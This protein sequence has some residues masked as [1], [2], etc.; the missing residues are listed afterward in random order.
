MT[1]VLSA[2]LLLLLPFAAGAAEPKPKP[3]PAVEAPST[4]EAG[5]ADALAA[6]QRQ[7]ATAVQPSGAG[8]AIIGSYIWGGRADLEYKPF[9]IWELRVK[10]GSAALSGLRSRT[11][12]LNPD[13]TPAATGAWQNI[14]A[15]APG[16]QV[17][18]SI[19]QN[20]TNFPAYQV[21][22]AW[23]GGTAAFVAWD[24]VALP[25]ALSDLA[26]TSFLIT[27]GYLHDPDTVT[28]KK[29]TEIAWHVWN[30]GGVAATEVEQVIHFFDDAGK[31]VKTFAVR[32][33]QV[34]GDSA[35]ACTVVV[36]KVPRY[37]TIS[38]SAT[39]AST[40]SAGAPDPG[41]FTGA[42]EVE[43]A[44]VRA[45]G[46]TLKAKVR[47]GLDKQLQGLVVLVTLLGKDGSPVRALRLPAGTLAAGDERELS[48]D[49][50]GIAAW[51]GYE[52]GWE[53]QAPPTSAATTTAGKPVR[54]ESDGLVFAQ[55]QVAQADGVLW[56]KGEL[57][58]H[59][60]EELAR[61]VLT[62]TVAGPNGE[63]SVEHRIDRLA[64]DE[65][66]MIALPLP[67]CTAIAGVRLAWT[68]AAARP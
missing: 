16:A 41:A 22:L 58:S 14:G 18:V 33:K 68:G 62:F 39:S 10:A 13:R 29:P 67:D 24:K 5:K 34:A 40:A 2:C 37:A 55:T 30:L 21:D 27:T 47:N 52:A 57:T 61:L 19:K 6:F 66:A 60:R 17:D 4:A 32:E 56:L 59:R 25:V 46:K 15:L 65:S 26:Q 45:E 8:P 23:Q 48:V 50:T 44:G 36:P 51:S 35:M 38:V 7:A 43:I 49:I 1:S 42:A 3:K 63:R 53:L 12:T 20:C 9:F 31:E 11:V 28:K 64:A 54:V